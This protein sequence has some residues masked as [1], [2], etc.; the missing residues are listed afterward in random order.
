MDKDFTGDSM[1]NNGRLLTLRKAEYG[2]AKE[3]LEYLNMIGG[4]SG[5]M[6]FGRNGFM[7]MTVKME[8]EHIAKTNSSPNTLMLL[9]FVGE[10]LVSVS[11]IR[12]EA[13]AR[14]AHNFE[15]SISVAKAHWGFGIGAA[16]MRHMIDFAQS[17][18]A[19]AIHLGVRAD[20]YAAVHLY[21]KFGF[22]KA[23]TRKGYF[24]INGEFY[25]ETLMALYI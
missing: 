18:G 15:L 3:V 13:P 23:G 11:Q 16:A 6:L 17:H 24:K 12:G 14:A 8:A 22:E 2:D 4:E 20:N 19:K 5:N 25:D 7:H 10:E 1:L 21:E 9:G